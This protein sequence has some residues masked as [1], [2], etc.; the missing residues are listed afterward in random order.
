MKALQEV[1]Q[2][3]KHWNELKLTNY[4]EIKTIHRIAVSLGDVELTALL[5]SVLHSDMDYRIP[6][7]ATFKYNGDMYSFNNFYDTKNNDPAK[8][9]VEITNVVNKLIGDV[10]HE[11]DVSCYPKISSDYAK[12]LLS[13]HA[14]KKALAFLLGKGVNDIAINVN[15][16]MCKDCHNFFC[17]VSKYY[18]NVKIICID[19][20]NEHRFVDGS[21]LS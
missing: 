15:M 7:M 6:V 2:H 8:Q 11:L 9:S 5:S 21:G 19:P 20:Y 18:P 3:I 1:K 14:E 12:R 16:R 13:H 17:N 4:G 10:N